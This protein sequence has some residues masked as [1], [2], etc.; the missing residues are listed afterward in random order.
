MNT[1]DYR[2]LAHPLM[3]ILSWK[4]TIAALLPMVVLTVACTTACASFTGCRTR[5]GQVRAIT[6]AQE[7]LS[8]IRVVKA[9]RAALRDRAV[10]RVEQRVRGRQSGYSA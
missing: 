7:N 9:T 1:R 5:A 8:G 10:R 6:R 3:A 2:Q 4:L